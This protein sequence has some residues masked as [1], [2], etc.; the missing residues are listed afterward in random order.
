MLLYCI[1][2]QEIIKQS[3]KNER[4]GMF[5]KYLEIAG[6]KK[7]SC[8]DGPGMRSVLFL[9]GCSMNCPGCHNKDIQKRGSGCLMSIEET[10]LYIEERCHNK[11]ITISGGEPLEQW[12]ALEELLVELRKRKFNIC[13]YTGWNY[14]K[15]PE[16]VFKLVDYIKTG[17][18]IIEKKN[19]DIHYVGSENQR[20]YHLTG[21]GVW[22]NLDLRL[23]A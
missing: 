18:F 12:E 13:I 9:Q 7:S 10:I 21:S 19:A 2:Q 22:E 15:V 23:S 11:R 20:M 3:Y 4:W 6:W 1:H 16:R 14:E 17:N 5:M 8:D